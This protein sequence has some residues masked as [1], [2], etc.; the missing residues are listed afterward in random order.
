MHTGQKRS[1][2]D[3]RDNGA[4]AVGLPAPAGMSK[5]AR[6]RAWREKQ[7]NEATSSINASTIKVG[8]TSGTPSEDV[9]KSARMKKLAEWR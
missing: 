1:R 5:L 4:E 9:T 2:S 8:S 3:D 6:L 7:S